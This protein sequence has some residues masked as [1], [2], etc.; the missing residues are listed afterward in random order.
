L[1]GGWRSILSHWRADFLV[2]DGVKKFSDSFTQ[3]LA[4]V[5]A[6]RAKLAAV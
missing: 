5:D 1:I 2:A 4:A 3:L 6:K